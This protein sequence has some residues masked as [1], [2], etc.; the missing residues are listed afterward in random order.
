MRSADVPHS[1]ASSAQQAE[2]YYEAV[3]LESNGLDCRADIPDLEPG[4]EYLVR[5]SAVNDQGPSLPSEP[6]KTSSS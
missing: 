6:G 2:L 5:V 3:P 4:L 1:S